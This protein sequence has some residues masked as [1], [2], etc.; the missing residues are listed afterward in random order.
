MQIEGRSTDDLQ[1]ISRCRLL[2]QRVP[3]FV[4]QP[5]ILNGDDGLVGK[6]RYQLDLLFRK[7]FRRGLSDEDDADDVVLAQERNAECGTI[8][9]DLLRRS[10]ERRVGKECRSR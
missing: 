5:R 8:T 9:G 6:R 10:E 7:W 1:D 2:L 4:E 3:Q